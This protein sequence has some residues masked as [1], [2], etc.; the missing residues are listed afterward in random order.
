MKQRDCTI[1]TCMERGKV[2]A[3]LMCAFVFAYA[4]SRFSYDAAN[5]F[6]VVVIELLWVYRT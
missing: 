4:K 3:R 1:S 6:V 2:F 5:V